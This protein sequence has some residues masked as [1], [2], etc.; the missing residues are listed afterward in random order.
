MIRRGGITM[1]FKHCQIFKKFRL[2]NWNVRTLLI[3]SFLI[4]GLV[5]LSILGYFTYDKSRVTIEKKVGTFSQQLVEQLA[6][7][8]A[9]KIKDIEES[10]TLLMRDSD[11]LNV[12][13]DKM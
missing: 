7:N 11:M 4:I 5:P 8:V 13:T 3:T 10:S 2:S 9:A 6:V 12:T 1:N